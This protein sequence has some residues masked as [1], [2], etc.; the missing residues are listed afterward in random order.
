MMRLTL[1]GIIL[2]LSMQ[3]MVGADEPVPQ[4]N[5]TYN[6]PY[7]LTETIHVL[8][9]VKINDQGPFN[10][11]IDTG[12]PFNFVSEEVAKKLKL[13]DGKPGWTNLKKFQIEGGIEKNDIKF[14]VETPFQLQGMNAMNFAGVELHGILGY[15]L[16]A[17]YKMELDVSHH[18]MRWTLLDYTPPLPQ[19]L[20]N[21]AEAPGGLNAMA[22][23]MKVMS[24]LV[25]K[26]PS[27]EYRPGG[28]LGLVLGEDGKT[29]RVKHVLENS[30]AALA[31][32]KADDTIAT[33]SGKKL[34]SLDELHRLASK[35]NAGDDIEMTVIRDGKEM[36]LTAQ[37]RKGL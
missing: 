21:K 34:S 3:S 4:K 12:A 16:L 25:G 19:I 37:A 6:V 30:P 15:T 7:K 24:M 26:M 11:I 17:Q 33:V 35:I 8:V 22:G 14:R 28:F 5:K 36:T 20:G 29:I 9:R 31:G 2:G 18:K 1:F 27:P 23:V 10:F 13:N 32:L